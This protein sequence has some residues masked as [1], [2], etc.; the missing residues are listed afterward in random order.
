MCSSF[1]SKLPSNLPSFST[2]QNTVMF[3]KLYSVAFTALLF[4]AMV[5]AL[6][7]QDSA[8]GGGL[9]ADLGEVLEGVEGLLGDIGLGL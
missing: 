3:S 8:A 1:F 4:V 7:T 5:A 6:P 9:S 2:Q